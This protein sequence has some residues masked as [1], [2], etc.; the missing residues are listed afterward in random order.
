MEQTEK[1]GLGNV[2][3]LSVT[4]IIRRDG[5]Y[6]ICRRSPG[7]KIFPGKWCVPGGKVQRSD[8]VDFPKDTEDH[9]FD[10]IEKALAREVLEETGLRV[11]GIGY[12]SSLALLHPSGRP[13]VIV[14]MRAD[15]AGGE[16]RLNDELTDHA[17]V[18]L[19]EA[20]SYDLI[21]GILGQMEKAHRAKD[22]LA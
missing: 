2:H 15:W 13:M 6:L 7:E 1:N 17:W 19:E 16:V 21:A 3:Y 14:S 9:W 5:R 4:C 20:K 12:V 18:T 8:I 22:E 11:T 10:V